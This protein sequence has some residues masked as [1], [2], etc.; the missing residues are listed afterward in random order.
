MLVERGYSV[1]IPINKALNP[2]A[3]TDSHFNIKSQRRQ[4]PYKCEKMKADTCSRY[5]K[6]NIAVTE[7]KSFQLILAN[8][9]TIGK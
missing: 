4:R 9:H 7:Q 6:M 5:I 1:Y 2:V 8:I 3:F